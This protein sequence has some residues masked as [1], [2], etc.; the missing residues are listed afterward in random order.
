LYNGAASNAAYN[1]LWQTA[2]SEGVAVFVAA[3]DQGSAVC[4]YGNSSGA[5]LTLAPAMAGLAVSGLASSPYDTAVGG[6]DFNWCNPTVE[7]S[8]NLNGCQTSAPYWSTTNASTLASALGYIPEV[9]WNDTCTTPA[10]IGYL[11]SF[12]SYF[13][14][15]G[16]NSAESACNFV[17]NDSLFVYQNTQGQ[18]DLSSWVNVVGGSGGAS[19]CSNNTTTISLNGTETLGTCTNG[20]TKPSYQ[21]ALTPA[22]GER[23]LP[24]VSFFAA[25]GLWNSSYLICVSE[26]LGGTCTYSATAENTYMEVGGTSVASPAMAGVMALINQKTGAPQG[27]P[28]TEL[29]KLAGQQ[30]YA[31]CSSEGPPSSSC[32]FHDVNQGTIAMP[33]QAGTPN[34]TVVTSGDTIGVL[35][36]Y[37]ATTGYDEA[38]GLGSLNVANVVNAFPTLA[39]AGTASVTVTP[40]LTSITANQTLT[41]SVT[42]ASK[43]AGG[44]T[45]TGTV[46]L[47]SGSYTSAVGTLSGG[48]FTFTIPADSLSA[49]TDTLTVSYSGD[50]TYGTATGSANVAVSKLAATVTV[51]P[52][53]MA[54]SSNQTLTVTGTVAGSGGTPTGTVTLSGGGY[55]SASTTLS[56]GSYSITIPANSLSGGADPLNVAYSGDATYSTQNGSAIV[57][58]TSV[59]VLTPTVTV[60]PASTTV[61][62]NA[63]LSVAAKVTGAGVTPTGTVTLTSGSYTSAAGTLSGGSFTFT[64]PAGSLANGSDTLTVSYS[65]D[66]NYASGTGTAS[67]TVNVSAFTLAASAAAAISSP[68]GTSS[69]TIT[70]TSTNGY[71]GTV[72]L[73]CILTNY[74]AGDIDLPTCTIPSAAV[75]AGGTATASVTTTSASAE[76]AY[77]KMDGRRRGWAGAGGGAVLALLLF[78]GIPARRRSWRTMVGMV[79]LMVMLGS[80]AGCGGGGGSTTTPTGTT[81]DTY[82]FTVTGTGSPAVTPAP[83]IT[84]S[85]TVN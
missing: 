10:G 46:T 26:V 23:D 84:F 80:L 82:T 64:I 61:D 32:Y 42:V 73:G 57:T 4:D 5:A 69:S 85:V 54:I 47:T 50:S 49:G 67:V 78:L 21:T 68:G 38:S 70:V 27:N 34:C 31:S 55:L 6:T 52:S 81:P 17:A 43:P 40:S 12:A 59:S 13:G 83:T 11:A 48:S 9:P 7:S 53:A 76:L 65:G 29:Y 60:T 33:C 8:G 16:V 71:T 20:W 37:G 1:T 15:S 77:P 3:G 56:S 36:G 30:S 28:N 58:V 74:T 19:N 18:I 22:D 79:V 62:S 63:S 41:V 72:T 25:N 14:I 39:G 24:D 2:A 45:P 35:S 51:T 75:A 66:G 44:T